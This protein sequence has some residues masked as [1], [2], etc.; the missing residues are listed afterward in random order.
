[1]VTLST[2][3]RNSQ[4]P[5]FTQLLASEQKILSS[6]ICWWW[7]ASFHFATLSHDIAVSKEKDGIG[8]LRFLGFIDD[9]DS[10]VMSLAL[11]Y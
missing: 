10:R 1:M 9:I 3:E 5:I 8:A 4:Q 7:I 2:L 6:A 11:R